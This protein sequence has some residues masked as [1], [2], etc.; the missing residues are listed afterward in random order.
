MERIRGL[1]RLELKQDGS[2]FACFPIASRASE[3]EPIILEDT[4]VETARSLYQIF[5]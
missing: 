3:F 2:V 5:S 4:N 1:T